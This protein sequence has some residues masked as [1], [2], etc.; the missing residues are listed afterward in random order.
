MLLCRETFRWHQILN[1]GFSPCLVNLWCSPLKANRWCTHKISSLLISPLAPWS[2]FKRSNWTCPLRTLRSRMTPTFRTLSTV[3]I[4]YHQMTLALVP[5]VVATLKLLL[6]AT[7]WSLIRNRHGKPS[8]ARY[9]SVAST[10]HKKRSSTLQVARGIQCTT[11][12][13]FVSAE[14]ALKRIM[15]FRER[16]TNRHV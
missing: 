6:F 7:G 16:K 11:T 15:I 4:P 10:R 9:I 5:S 1:N 3:T 2:K 14:S 8:N 12:T 13:S